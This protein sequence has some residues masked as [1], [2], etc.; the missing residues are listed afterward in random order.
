MSRERAT[1]YAMRRLCE[2]QKLARET[3]NLKFK[4]KNP[5]EGRRAP[6]GKFKPSRGEAS[7]SG[8]LN[9]LDFALTPLIFHNENGFDDLFR[10][11]AVHRDAEK[12]CV[13]F[14]RRGPFV[15]DVGNAWADRRA[16]GLAGRLQ[17]S[18]SR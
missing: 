1:N 15:L 8:V 16:V 10:R 14:A 5:S 9:A 7:L 17:R 2:L 12:A 6:V 13:R 3:V 4:R 18:L 11:S